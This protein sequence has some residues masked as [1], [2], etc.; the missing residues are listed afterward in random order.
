V[1][2][3][4][5]GSA[6]VQRRQTC[7]AGASPAGVGARGPVAWMAG[8]RESEPLKPIDEAIVRMVSESP[9]RNERERRG[10]LESAELRRPSGCRAGEG[11]RA[12]RSLADAAVSLRR[13]GS[14]G[15]VTRTRRATGEALLVPPRNRRSK[16]GRITGA[17]GK[18]ADDERV[19][20]GPAVAT[21]RGNARGAKGPCCSAQ[22]PTTWKAGAT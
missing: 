7:S 5:H 1:Q 10:S 18:S 3:E 12:R 6:C 15:T 17:P 11:S 13:G 19:A 4:A 22:P 16:V 9:G 8:G 14:D 20:E 21:K 2:G